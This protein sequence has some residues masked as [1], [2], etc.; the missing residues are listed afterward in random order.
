MP[1]APL[2][3]CA[4]LRAQMAKK[5]QVGTVIVVGTTPHPLRDLYHRLLTTS[6][7]GAIGGIGGAFL[8]I[9]FVFAA[10]YTVT[11]GIE[12]MPGHGTFVDSFFF[13]AQTLG[14][15]GYG[16]MHPVSLAANLVVVVETLVG[17]LFIAV[18]TGIVFSRFSRSGESIVFCD[19]PCITKMDG[20]PTLM[21]RIGNDR[22]SAIVDVRIRLGF[23]YS[24]VTTEGPVI[25]RMLDLPLMRD[26]APTLA[27]TWSVMHV[28]DEKS[29]LYGLTPDA[30]AKDESEL[31]ISV[32]GTDGI[33]LLPVFGQ[34]RYGAG[35]LRWGSRFVDVLTELPDGNLQLDVRKFH[36]TVLVEGE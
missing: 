24:H 36:D 19:N 22:D 28:I 5:P 4:T 2:A 7:P 17:I 26:R 18:A 10:V 34:R 9:N 25:Y 35:A 14:T 11:D 13:S 15:I 6:W 12:G 16:A 23:V 8:A 29:P 27:R 30:I 33:S 20:V 32:I 31:L 21:F 3:F 1:P